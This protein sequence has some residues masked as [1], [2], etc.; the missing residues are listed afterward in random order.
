MLCFSSVKHFQLY[1]QCVNSVNSVN[2]V[3]REEEEEKGGVI[4][5]PITP[6]EMEVAPHYKLLTLF[7]MLT[8]F[9]LLG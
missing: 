9:T 5:S 7:K 4:L 3:N 8:W 2:S 6:S 1:E